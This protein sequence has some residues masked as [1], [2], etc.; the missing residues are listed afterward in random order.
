M[1]ALVVGVCLQGLVSCPTL[2]Q[3][4]REP[5]VFYHETQSVEKCQ[6]ILDKLIIIKG[7]VPDGYGAICV[8]GFTPNSKDE[9]EDFAHPELFSDSNS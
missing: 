3:F 1:I 2:D 9:V 7:P 4:S 6:D 8:E 5:Y